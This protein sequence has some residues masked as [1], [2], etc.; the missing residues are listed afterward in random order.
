MREE[1]RETEKE[2]MITTDRQL[3]WRCTH[4]RRRWAESGKIWRIQINSAHW[5]SLWLSEKMIK[6]LWGDGRQISGRYHARI[7][8]GYADLPEQL[9][10]STL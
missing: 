6:S 5:S 7:I 2:I 3:A 8:S 1:V 10:I 9:E 4:L